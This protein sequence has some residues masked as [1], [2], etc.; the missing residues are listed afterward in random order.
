M[1]ILSPPPTSTFTPSGPP[2]VSRLLLPIQP[3]DSYVSCTTFNAKGHITSI[4]KRYPKMQFLSSHGLYPRDLRKIDSSTIDIIPSIVVRDTCFLVNLLHIK[5]IVMFDKVM[6]FDTSV[7]ALAKKIGLFMYDLENKL[8]TQPA[9]TN[10]YNYHQDYEHRALESILINVMSSLEAELAEHKY[11]CGR[12]LEDLED[13]IDRVK[14]KD[15]LV[16]S[17]SLGAFYQKALLIKNVLDELLDNDED[18]AKLYL[19]H[20]K[21]NSMDFTEVEMLLEAYYI[22]CDEFVQQAESLINDIKSTEEIINII[23]DANRNSLMLFELKVTIYTLGFTVATIAPAFYGMN[24]KNFV[25]ESEVGF[26]AVCIFSVVSAL[27]FTFINFKKLGKV[28]RLAMAP[29]PRKEK[30]EVSFDKLRFGKTKHSVQDSK[31]RAVI[32][33][34]L[35]NETRNK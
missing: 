14:L 22:Q 13:Q 17:K 30:P 23:L 26:A 3:N 9:G 34:W 18:L 35:V 25:E 21:N 4:S 7:T 12:I 27:W 28:R 15:L 11:H 1:T 2:N 29:T 8:S 5:A 20:K 16:Y 31:R 24:L 6:V 32:W 10:H 33:R 19:S